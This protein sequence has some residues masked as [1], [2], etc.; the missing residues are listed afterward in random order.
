V[1]HV[2]GARDAGNEGSLEYG[3]ELIVKGFSMRF[4]I[5]GSFSRAGY[6]CFGIVRKYFARLNITFARLTSASSG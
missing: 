6:L 2:S 3:I 4:T 1:I 5:A